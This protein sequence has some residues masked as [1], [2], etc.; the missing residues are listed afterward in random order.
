MNETLHILKF[1]KTDKN[2]KVGKLD[3][4]EAVKIKDM[5]T[6]I[7]DTKAYIENLR[8]GLENAK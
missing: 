2:I 6:I 5:Q 1:F 8:K 4:S 3:I 7:K